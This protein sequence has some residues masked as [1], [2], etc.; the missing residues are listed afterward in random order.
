MVRA[1]VDDVTHPPTVLEHE[2]PVSAEA[3]DDRLGRARPHAGHRYPRNRC[4]RL[5]D[6]CCQPPLQPLLCEDGGRPDRLVRGR[7]AQDRRDDEFRQGEGGHVKVDRGQLP[8]SDLDGGGCVA[9]ASDPE[10]IPLGIRHGDTE[11]PVAVR[12]GAAARAEDHYRRARERHP[13]LLRPD[14]PADD[15]P[16]LSHLRSRRQ[17]GGA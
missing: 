6:G 4:N 5:R 13:V 2:D 15:L 9:E 7:G 17:R 14:D 16:V 3:A 10:P 12:D 1:A 8:A 11:R